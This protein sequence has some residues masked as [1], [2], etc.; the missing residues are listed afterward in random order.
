MKKILLSLIIM[1]SLGIACQ[2]VPKGDEMSQSDRLAVITELEDQVFGASG[3][4]NATNMLSLVNNYGKYAEENPD[5]EMTPS[6]LFKA[7]D[8]CMG[9]EKGELAIGYFQK[10]IENYPDF[11]K[12]AYC[13][14][15]KAFIYENNLNDLENAKTSYEIF[16][17]RFP[18]HEMTESAKFSLKN[19]GKSPE[20][21]IR[22]FEEQNQTTPEEN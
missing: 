6:Y 20:D 17:E 7:G 13:Y 21:L 14:F 5:D 22:E 15:L 4:F 16:I 12:V 11:E 10:L 8:I 3:D 18:D 9:L 19:L 1:I 2:D